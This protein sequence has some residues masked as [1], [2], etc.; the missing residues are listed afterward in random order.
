MKNIVFILLLHAS[1]LRP[2]TPDVALSYALRELQIEYAKKYEKELSK[3]LPKFSVYAMEN[4]L[5]YE[6]TA[7]PSIKITSF[8]VAFPQN[9]CSDSKNWGPIKLRRCRVKIALL[10]QTD[11][12]VRSIA[13]TETDFKPIRAVQSRIVL[14]ASSLLKTIHIELLKN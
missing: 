9:P 14:K 5:F 2:Q 1:I 12:L 4:T 11:K 6:A 7:V 10:K 8:S 13:E 3:S